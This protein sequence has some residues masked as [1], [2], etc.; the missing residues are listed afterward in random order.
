MS[1]RREDGDCPVVLVNTG[2]L[3]NTS[4]KGQIIADSFNQLLDQI[5]KDLLS[6]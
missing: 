2:Y 6:Y 4:Y 1:V 5:E 3:Q